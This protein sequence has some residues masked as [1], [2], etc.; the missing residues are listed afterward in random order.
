MV[1]E[2]SQPGVLWAPEKGDSCCLL[3]V[4][5]AKGLRVNPGPCPLQGHICLAH[6]GA[7]MHQVEQA[8]CFVPCKGWL[9]LQ[10]GSQQA[11]IFCKSPQPHSGFFVVV[12]HCFAGR[13]FWP[14]R[15]IW[16]LSSFAPL[17][18][19]LYL[20]NSQQ[21]SCPIRWQLESCCFVIHGIFSSWSKI[22]WLICPKAIFVFQWLKH[23]VNIKRFASTASPTSRHR[24]GKFTLRAAYVEEFSGLPECAAKKGQKERFLYP[25]KNLMLPTRTLEWFYGMMP[26]FLKWSS[27]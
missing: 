8:Q 16:S 17:G 14:G 21:S 24:V 5:I 1:A 22:D 19:Q 4:R 9:S 15:V 2:P 25:F 7:W 12:P 18:R 20:V 23:L 10:R 11:L 6:V 27:V 3:M 13:P 26:C